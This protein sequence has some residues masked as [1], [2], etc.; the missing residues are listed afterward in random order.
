MDI[1][2][3][4]SSPTLTILNE[5]TV[6]IQQNRDLQAQLDEFKAQGTPKIPDEIALRLQRLEDE[7]VEGVLLLETDGEPTTL[8]EAF[9]LLG[10]SPGP[11][12]DVF[13]LITWFQEVLQLSCDEDA[14]EAVMNEYITHGLVDRRY[15]AWHVNVR[16]QLFQPDVAFKEGLPQFVSFTRC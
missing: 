2:E 1:V 7:T 9:L 3:T 11:G 13:D 4:F 5:L 8:F 16:M 6:L 10:S 12:I 14:I 15:V